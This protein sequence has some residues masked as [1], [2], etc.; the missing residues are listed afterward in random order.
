[1]DAR[2]E[3]LPEVV[4]L[5]EEILNER[6]SSRA[7]ETGAPRPKSKKS[8][9]R[10]KR[11]AQ[12]ARAAANAASTGAVKVTPSPVETEESA[13]A[14][15]DKTSASEKVSVTDGTSVDET[16]VTYGTS[17][18]ETSAPEE[19]PASDETPVVEEF[20]AASAEE[21][22][23]DTDWQEEEEV[24]LPVSRDT[25][26][27]EALSVPEEEEEAEDEAPSEAEA[28]ATPPSIL[29]RLTAG[30]HLNGRWS[31]ARI[32]R[33]ALLSA[34]IILLVL[35]V[36]EAVKVAGIVNSVNYA[37]K[38][39]FFNKDDVVV[40]QSV[41][42][43]F[44]SHSDDTKQILLIGYDV[45]KE[46]TRRSDSM[47]ILTLDHENRMIK[48]S[49]LMR[50]MYV[51]IPRHGKTKL[52]AAFA[53]GANRGGVEEGA[54]LLLET[55]HANFGME[56][57]NYICVD[58][59]AFI[60]VVDEIGGIPID[61]EEMELE[62]FNKYVSGGEKNRI[63]EAGS[64]VFNGRQTLSYCRIRKVGSD[65]VRTMRQR[66]VLGKIVRKCSKMSVFRLEKLLR[67][68]APSVTT[69]LS[70]TEIFGLASEGLSSKDY[71]IVGLRIPV[72]GAWTDLTVD[73]ISYVGVDLN[74]NARYLYQFVYGD[75]ETVDALVTKQEKS[76]EANEDWERR[77]YERKKEREER[78]NNQ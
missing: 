60:D 67:I 21:A 6:R 51:K 48:M 40:S 65:T 63:Y 15:K 49:S 18:D 78:R 66:E 45:D 32:I 71:D 38:N 36:W 24:P 70:M 2:L 50:D 30:F 77:R 8:R 10:K 3:M 34:G 57:D 5:T 52:N 55:I 74:A 69:N 13:P 41:L 20:S 58:Y 37:G 4:S 33:T 44:V 59:K 19:M 28:T 75:S 61:I 73:G 62:Q 31:R 14:A 46:G 35:L 39:H 12:A 17:V 47:I 53:Y 27:E 11:A 7:A 72:D 16:S 56:I 1:M 9:K 42:E 68:T 54:E 43:Q 23:E 64:Y 76:D 22:E 26:D 29:S 25:A